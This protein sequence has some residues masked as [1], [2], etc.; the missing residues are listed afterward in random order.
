MSTGRVRIALASMAAA[1]ALL[2]LHTGEAQ[3]PQEIDPMRAEASARGSGES[4]LP[5]LPFDTGSRHPQTIPAPA[6]KE[7]VKAPLSMGRKIWDGVE[8]P[9]ERWRSIVAL[10]NGKTPKDKTWLGQYCA[11]TMIAPTW[12]LT[13]AHCVR[14]NFFHYGAVEV[15]PG[16]IRIS[17]E[18]SDKNVE[19][20]PTEIH[21]LVGSNDLEDWREG[22]SK[23][24]DR[25]PVKR[26]LQAPFA[27]RRFD[28]TPL[29]DVALLELQRAPD[30]AVCFDL[31]ALQTPA[32]AALSQPGQKVWAAGWG[33][34]EGRKTVYKLRHVDIEVMDTPVCNKPMRE[35]IEE[36]TK[37]GH[38]IVLWRMNLPQ[39]DIDRAWDQVKGRGGDPIEADMMC[40]GTPGGTKDAC[41]GDS[42]G[43]LAADV[44]GR[45][46]Q[47]GV[48]S[49]GRG[50]GKREFKGVYARLRTQWNWIKATVGHEPAGSTTLPRGCGPGPAPAR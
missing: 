28:G 32:Q 39:P 36:D 12:V 4:R 25:I 10:I 30:A 3:Q 21:I 44:G 20:T 40:A 37:L 7:S 33:L 22:R 38:S 14:T 35:A 19:V 26:I 17:D 11:G 27:D 13:A 1:I 50:C 41:N 23:P 43:P 5:T 6:P 8:A 24:V 9:P 47:V 2:M 48:V 42:G 31:M 16:D 45:L 18:I 15:R 49:W 34:M 46:V 29:N